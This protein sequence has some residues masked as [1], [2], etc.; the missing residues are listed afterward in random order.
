MIDL[1]NPRR[2]IGMSTRWMVVL[3]LLLH[4]GSVSADP[5]PIAKVEDFE[6][7]FDASSHA[8]VAGGMTEARTLTNGHVKLHRTGPDTWTGTG[9]AHL[10]IHST[11][12]QPSLSMTSDGEADVSGPVELQL[13]SGAKYHITWKLGRIAVTVRAEIVG[14]PPNVSTSKNSFEP[15]EPFDTNG[16][17][18]ADKLDLVADDDHHDR[19]NRHVH[20]DL[21]AKGGLV[22]VPQI[23]S[24]QR[25]AKSRLDGSASTPKDGIRKYHWKLTPGSDCPAGTPGSTEFDGAVVELTLLCSMNAALTVSDDKTSDTARSAAVVAVRPW[26][27]KP[28]KIVGPDPMPGVHFIEGESHFGQ[29]ICAIEPAD[30]DSATHIFHRG[31]A[32]ARAGTWKDDAYVLKSVSDAKS[33]FDHWWYISEYKGVYARRIRINA[34]LNPKSDNGEANKAAGHAKDLA[35]VRDCAIKHETEHDT[36]MVKA[37]AAGWDPA[38]KLE[39]LFFS[40]AA[41][42]QRDADVAISDTENEFANQNFFETK[43]HAALATPC[44]KK[45]TILMG[46]DTRTFSKVSDIGD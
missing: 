7:T 15:A 25:G 22:A 17:L 27:T 42:L 19:S 4:R 20:W 38:P 40:S 34:D 43:V 45:A 13:V 29:Q 30:G 10:A 11:L 12:K 41:D 8:N 26:K 32:A 1:A 33:P 24:V 28:V 2:V 46:S 39:K 16:E 6:G 31:A 3:V 37:L 18:P 14:Q 5:S 35:F 44:G 23:V 9:T 21:K 36:Q